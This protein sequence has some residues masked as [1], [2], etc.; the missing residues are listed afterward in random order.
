MIEDRK[1]GA[2]TGAGA[3]AVAAAD[4]GD[5]FV[6]MVSAAVKVDLPLGEF[7]PRS[8]L[9]TPA[10]L[11]ERPR[12][13]VIDYHNHLDSQN[14]SELLKVM[15][16]CD[17]ELL[18]NITMQVGEQALQ[19][20]DRL[21]AVARGRFS[22]IGWMDWNGVERADFARLSCERMDRMAEHGACGIKFWKDLGLSVREASGE[23]L[24]I[25]DE[26][27]APIFDKAAELNFPVMFHT[28]DPDAFFEPIDAQN[29]RYEELAAHPDWG[30][31]H[32]VYTKRELLEQRN[33]VFARH[34]KTTFMGAHLAESGEDLE[35][36]AGLLERYANLQIDIS[37]R[38]PEL[39][40]QPYRAREFFLKYADRILFGTDLLPEISMYRLYYRFLETADE[41]FEY[42]SHASR[43]GR[44]NIYG[45]FL[46]EDVLKKV[47]R[48]NAERLLVVVR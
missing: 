20:M 21:H 35:Y 19:G 36:L 11:V 18:V 31:H 27:L 47:Y 3:A 22:T 1:G 9:K 39:G 16:T 14:P 28:A 32:S 12:F 13:P 2:S 6:D 42:P 7:Q 43:Q 29:E 46:P 4:K 10:H 23:L 30:F 24:R 15:D 44:W 26:R 34:P 40:R 5:K 38:T 33:R 8:S 41:Y 25:D 45:L 48:E 17:V 37:A